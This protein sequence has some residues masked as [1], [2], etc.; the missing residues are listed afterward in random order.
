MKEVSRRTIPLATRIMFVCALAA[1]AAVSVAARQQTPPMADDVFKNIQVLR[2]LTV[3]E[4]MGTMGFISASLSMNCSD[5]HDP[6]NAASYAA[7]NPRKQMARQMIVMVDTL[8]KANFGGRRVVTC[9]SCHRGADRPKITP[10]LAEQ[11]GS[12]PEDDPN[13]V[14]IPRTPRPNSPSVDQVLDRY[15]QALG[16]AQSLAALNSFV[17]RGTYQGFD[18]LGD[19][20]RVDVYA[21]A[22]NQ[23]ATVV[24]L[25]SGAADNVR[26]FDGQSAW[27]TSTGT[28][29][30]IPVVP[31]TAGE[32]EG[33]K[34]E[35]ALSFPGQIKQLLTDWR[36]GFPSTA[37]DGRP[38]DVVQAMMADN[39]PAKFYFDRDTGLLVRLVRYTN[40]RLGF[41][42]TQID[43]ADY[44]TVLGVKIPFKMTTTWTDGQSVI[45]LSELQANVP[46]DAARF[47][48]PMPQP[49]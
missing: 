5:C 21:K 17:A 28:L 13:E 43:Y 37:I 14:E 20:V 35:A 9:Y 16:G 29:M 34:L 18:T 44:R 12:P 2:G 1:G 42:P 15:I 6:A 36:S 23:R 7:D 46:I 32:L 3:D 4:F 22:P 33:A 49:R 11:Y 41:N 45:A 38:V 26:V 39:T 10:S 30:P 27:N 48:K 19:T 47:A 40:T 31:L 8:N 25:G 24:H